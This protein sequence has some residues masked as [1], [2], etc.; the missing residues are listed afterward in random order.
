MT[1]TEW[2]EAN[3]KGK[4]K[5][6]AL[7]A[8]DEQPAWNYNDVES[9]SVCFTWVITK[10]GEDYWAA[11]CEKDTNPDQWL[12]EDY[13]DVDHVPGIGEMVKSKPFYIHNV[14]SLLDEHANEKISFSKMVE[15]MN[16]MARKFYTP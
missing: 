2:V 13:V 6:R 8:C 10:E 11:V 3:L 4:V 12:P 16:E 5:A 15:I 7:R 9:L 1:N 14:K